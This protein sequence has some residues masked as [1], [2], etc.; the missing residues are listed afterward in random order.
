MGGHVC[1]KRTHENFRE[2]LSLY[3]ILSLT[4]VSTVSASWRAVSQSL[5]L[6]PIHIYSANVSTV[7]PDPVSNSMKK[8]GKKMCQNTQ[9]CF[10]H[11]NE[12]VVS[13][14]TRWQPC[15]S[16]LPTLWVEEGQYRQ[17]KKQCCHLPLL[18]LSMTE[19]PAGN[20]WPGT[21]GSE[22]LYPK[23]DH[24]LPIHLPPHHHHHTPSPI[25][26]C[27]PSWDNNF[28]PLMIFLG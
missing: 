8:K 23:D 12:C 17:S 28:L 20:K 4:W 1:E 14:V 16:R 24:Y 27:P 13:R 9:D 5:R 6:P 3:E 2:I 10:L 22:L 11:T 26:P 15:V 7:W 18:P 25:S 19:E 21:S